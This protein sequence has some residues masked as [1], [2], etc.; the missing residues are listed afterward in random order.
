MSVGV[1][2]GGQQFLDLPEMGKLPPNPISHLTGSQ[3]IIRPQKVQI[4]KTRGQGGM[5]MDFNGTGTLYADPSYVLTIPCGN[6]YRLIFLP[7]KSQ[8]NS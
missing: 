1:L 8:V 7:F 6:W 4:L 3:N 5:P 2:Y